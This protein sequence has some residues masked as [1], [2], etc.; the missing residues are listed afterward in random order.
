MKVETET[1]YLRNFIEKD[2]DVVIDYLT[3]K[4]VMEYMNGSLS[5]ESARN[6]FNNTLLENNLGYYAMAFKDT[7][8]IFGQMTFRLVE[9]NVYEMAWICDQKYWQQGFT[10]ELCTELITLHKQEKKDS[11][12]ILTIEKDNYRAIELAKKLE[13]CVSGFTDEMFT[14]CRY[15]N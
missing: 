7:D 14:F 8:T 12:I 10:F 11:K 1:T 15:M 6:Y 13:F 5:E 3:N 2:I 4:E 9:N